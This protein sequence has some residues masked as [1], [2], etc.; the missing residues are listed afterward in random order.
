MIVFCPSCSSRHDISAPRLAADGGMVRCNAC[1]HNWIEGRAVEVVDVSP[2]AA[3]PVIEHGFEPD[4][5]VRRLLEA[6][7]EARESFEAKRKRRLAR[8]RGWG[9]LCAVTVAP[10]AA[11]AALP[12][13][14]VSYAPATIRAYQALGMDVNIYGL[15]IRRV[16][17]QHSI[18]DGMRVLSIKGEIANVSDSSA[19]MPWLRFGLADATGAEVYFWTLDTGARP[20]RAGE[21]T[22][23]TTRVAA[24][25]E[26]AQ[27]VHIRFARVHEIGSNPAP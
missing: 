8:I 2:R 12:E 18:I 26:T 20:L 11:A 19:K 17:Q 7:R 4:R 21:I 23:F 10:F 9:I 24:P 16:E 1:G 14:V 15:E 25:P 22:T 13:T 27:K 3:P 6:S 5:E